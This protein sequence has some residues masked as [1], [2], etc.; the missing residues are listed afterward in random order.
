MADETTQYILVEREGAVAT[1]IINRPDKLN[2]LNWALVAELARDLQALD[3][4]DAIGAIVLTGA[5]ERAFAAG[6]DIAE[7]SDKTPAQM[8]F[9]AFEGWGH[10]RRIKKP[11][12]AAVEGFA[13]GGGSELAMHA[14]IIIASEKAKFGQP[15]ILLGIM[16]GAGGTQRLTGAIG[17]YRA[18]EMCL[19]GE[20]FTA[21]QMEA[22]GLVNHVVAPGQARAEATKLA[23]KIAAQAPVATRMIKET[24]LMALETPLEAGLAYEKRVFAM[25][26]STEDQKEGMAA[27][28]EKRKADFKGR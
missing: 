8:A 18:M 6:A 16:P 11:I 27:F 2:A 15:E 25:L 5:G 13:L 20:Q 17:K 22:W 21:Q 28:M 9:G 26:F 4:D 10:I 19:T 3:A 24:I 14:D 23:Q 12:I 1:V 7:M